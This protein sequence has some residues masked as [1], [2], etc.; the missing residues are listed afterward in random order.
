MASVNTPR[1][2]HPQF[3]LML[4]YARDAYRDEIEALCDDISPLLPN[5]YETEAQIAE[6]VDRLYAVGE[7]IELPFEQTVVEEHGNHPV[8][9]LIEAIRQ[10]RP[11]A[12]GAE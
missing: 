8:D 7:A 10:Y 5:E 6:Y 11:D 12:F 9:R 3:E 2:S 4:D 1:R